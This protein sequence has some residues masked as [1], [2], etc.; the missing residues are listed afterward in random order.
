LLLAERWRLIVVRSAC[1]I[2]GGIDG[3]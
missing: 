2:V 1:K 3:P